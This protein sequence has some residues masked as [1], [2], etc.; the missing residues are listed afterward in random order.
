MNLSILPCQHKL[1]F[2]PGCSNILGLNILASSVTPFLV[3]VALSV[4]SIY[5]VP[6]VAC[7]ISRSPQS[8]FICSCLP[9]R[10]KYSVLFNQSVL[11]MDLGDSGK[12]DDDLLYD[13]Y[14]QY[15]EPYNTHMYVSKTI[16]KKVSGVPF[17][18]DIV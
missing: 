4:Y 12:Y 18:K 13:T 14:L 17:F 11:I 1:D 3:L 2:L 5:L 16:I 15:L 7:F 9:L 6:S 10:P 8:M